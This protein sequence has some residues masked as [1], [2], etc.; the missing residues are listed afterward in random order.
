MRTI[1]FVIS[2]KENERRRALIPEDLKKINNVRKLYFESGYGDVLGY[3]DDA[4]LDL[5]ANV[6]DRETVYQQDIICNP[7]A[8]EPAERSLFR[9]GQTLFGWIHAVQGREITDFLLEKRMTAIAWEN[10]FENG[11][12]AFWRNNEIAGEAAVLHAFLFLGKLPYECHVAVLGRGNCARGAIRIL[13]KLGAK[14]TVYD[15]KTIPHLQ[16]ELG[17]YDVIINT[18]LWDVF[19]TDRLIY[20]KDLKLMKQGAMII[21]VSCNQSLEIE[22]SH[23]TTIDNPTYVVDGVIHYVVDHTASLFWKSASRAISREVAKYIDDLVEDKPNP[24]LNKAK[25]IEQGRI[26]DERIARFQGR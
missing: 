4:Y 7:K 24:A 12:H 16:N 26:L 19:R 25:I 17:N 10:I 14:I 8:P 9:E 21:D 5:G 2:Q 6:V 18:V 3:P 23:A 1:G 22:T 20:R 13:E 15:R 11:R